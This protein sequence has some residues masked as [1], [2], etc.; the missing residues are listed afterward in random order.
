TGG[1][2]TSGMPTGGGLTSGM[3]TGGG[4]TSGMP[5]GGGL[6]SGMPTGSEPAD[7]EPTGA[8]PTG[9]KPDAGEPTGDELTAGMLTWGAPDGSE[10]TDATPT[11]GEPADS[12]PPGD[13]LTGRELTGREL[14]SGKPAGSR[15]TSGVPA[16]GGAAG[17]GPD[18]RMP[19]GSEPAGTGPGSTGPDGDKP[20]DHKPDRDGPDGDGPDGDG[21]DG[22]GPD[23]DGPDRDGPDGGGLFDGVLAGGRVRVEAGDAAWLRALLDAEAALALAA[24]DAGLAD[25]SDARAVAAACAGI[26]VDIAALGAEAAATGNPVVPLVRRVRAVLPAGPAALVHRGATSQDIVDTAAMLVAWRAL[27]PLLDDLGG[28]ADR[29]AG[30]ADRHRDTIMPGRTLLQQALPTTFGLVAAGW[31]SGLDTAHRALT[32]LREH[33]LAAQLGGAVGTLAAYPAA[34]SGPLTAAFAG[35]LGLM[36]PTIPWHTE[37]TRIAELAAA[38]GTAAG[39]IGKVAR[40]VTLHAQTEV[41]EL[42][43]GGGAGVSSTMPHKRNPVHAISAAAAAATTPGLVATVLAAMP[44]EYQRAAGAWQAEW[45]PIRSLLVAVGSAAYRIRRCLDGLEVHAG[46]M[47]ANLDLTHG[48]LLAERVAAAL[49][50]ALGADADRVV[51][52]AAIRGDLAHDPAVTAHLSS[53]ELAGLL[54]P[55]GYLGSTPALID[56]ALIDRALIDQALRAAGR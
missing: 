5:T 36:E 44:H 45:Q 26:E 28:A 11:G 21:P 15:P 37:R 31:L 20:D 8:T 23:R 22:D 19:T 34:L 14:T 4:L 42:S 47:R 39:A 9:R 12:E 10:P 18:S 33:R 35:R 55:A 53:A 32:T 17:D 46:R 52:A 7:S 2:L 27:G 40:D 38:L 48:A 54:D 49:R 56:R 24:S 13:E 3:P 1:G 29:A 25:A 16:G 6:T 51:R 50:P 30:L 41:G 43:E